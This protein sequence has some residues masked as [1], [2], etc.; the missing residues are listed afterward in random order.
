MTIGIALNESSVAITQESTEGTY[1]A[2]TAGTDFIQVL[3]EV[4]LIDSKDL[5]EREI[6]TSDVEKSAPRV[7]QKS[8]AATVPVELKAAANASAGQEPEADLLFKGLMGGRRQKT[9]QTTSKNTAHSSTVVYIDDDDI[10]DFQVGDIVKVL[11]AGAFEV[12]PISTVTQTDGACSITF[13]FALE[14]GAPSNS[15]VLEKFTTYYPSTIAV[16]A[17]QETYTLTIPATAAAAQGDFVM[18]YDHDG[19]SWAVWFDIDAAGTEPN[20]AIYS[21]SDNQIE[22]DIATGGSAIANALA[23]FTAVDGVVTNVGF[24]NNLDGTIAVLLSTAGPAPFDAVSYVEAEDATGS[25]T[26]GTITDGVTAVAASPT[27]SMTHYIGGEIRHKG[28]GM[29]VV[30]GT[31]GNFTT[32]QVASMSFAL[33][34]LDFDREDGSPLYDPSFGSNEPPV[35]LE[36]CVWLNGTKVQCN[37]VG[38]SIEN[39]VGF[40]T[41]TCSSNGKISSRITG[42]KV[43][44]TIN[45]YM[46]D[47]NVAAR[48]ERFRDNDDNTLFFITSN[49]SGTDGEDMEFVCFWIPKCK[50][51]E[52]GVGDQEG[53]ATD[54]LSFQAFR[55]SGNDTLFIGM[56]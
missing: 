43:T 37:E 30:G 48:F 55:T 49:P 28:I 18:L 54:A 7:G 44:G 6:L 34:G 25:I 26:V 32:A 9:T 33:Q 21:A 47:T 12:R 36:S 10:T 42:F 8:A 22:V 13:P 11:E 17:V 27:L 40:L 3:P 45:P 52:S 31:L 51:V 19:A 14:N 2:E 39:Q 29:R 23:F 1:V 50:L 24:T 20:G 53:I 15:V 5:I 46:D 38:L 56:I 16:S 41:S 35:I 4:E